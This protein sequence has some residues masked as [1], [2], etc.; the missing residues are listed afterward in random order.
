MEVIKGVIGGFGPGLACRLVD[1][2]AFRS[3]NW[4][5]YGN[6]Q[7]RRRLA[8]IGIG[9]NRSTE[10]AAGLTFEA[11]EGIQRLDRSIDPFAAA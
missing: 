1:S 2:I 10:S 5:T 4:C 7:R 6:R 9:Q 3:H 8:S 11:P